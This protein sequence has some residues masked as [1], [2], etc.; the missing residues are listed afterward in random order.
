MATRAKMPTLLKKE[1]HSHICDQPENPYRQIDRVL[2]LH[3]GGFRNTLPAII[4]ASEEGVLRIY[5]SVL[6]KKKVEVAI[7]S[8]RM[9]RPAHTIYFNPASR[10]GPRTVRLSGPNDRYIPIFL[11]YNDRLVHMNRGVGLYDD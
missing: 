3:A 10:A 6:S 8:D 2:K 1:K 5:E 9:P 11:Q 4:R 7:P